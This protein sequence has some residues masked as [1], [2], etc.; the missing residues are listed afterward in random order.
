MR[1][2]IDGYAQQYLKEIAHY[3]LPYFGEM[4]TAGDELVFPAPPQPLSRVRMLGKKN[5]QLFGGVY[6]LQI[7]GELDQPLLKAD[8]N[9]IRISYEGW[10][11]KGKAYF[12]RDSAA[13]QEIVKRLNSHAELIRTLSRLDLEFGAISAADG[14]Y[15]VE[16]TPLSGS[17]MYMTIPPLRYPGA[18][19]QQEV[20]GLARVICQMSQ[21]LKAG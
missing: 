7:I 20:N 12:K 17:Y 15:R 6:S 21:I 11:I 13:D 2:K 9:P 16:L 1:Q 10:M 14:G 4:T 18:I 3:F 5:K 8:R 19:S